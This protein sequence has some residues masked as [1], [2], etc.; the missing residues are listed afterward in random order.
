MNRPSSSIEQRT[1]VASPRALGARPRSL[2][3]R[4]T[5]MWA[6]VS[7]LVAL[8]I[9]CSGTRETRTAGPYVVAITATT[10]PVIQSQEGGLYQMQR[11]VGLPLAERPKDLPSAKP[12]PGGV[13]YTPADLRVQV[14]YVISNLED[15]DVNVELLVDGWNEFIYYA[16]QVSLDAEGQ[17]QADRSCVDRL[18]IVPAKGRVTGTV[19]F[20]DFERMAMAL[21]TVENGA[22]NPHHV[23]DPSTTFDDV[24]VKP[25]LPA[26]IDGITGFDVSLRTTEPVR[27]ALEATVELVDLAGV[28]LD[29]GSTTTSRRPG[30]AFVPQVRTMGM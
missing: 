12:Y 23:M 6:V 7:V 17:V 22:P 1:E 16:P 15:K 13:W 9:A 18:M 26:V 27:V 21:A 5:A 20:D 4:V 3:A 11:S 24:L 14:S 29:E 8:A 19:S 30:R 25:Y 2:A 28:L 10:P